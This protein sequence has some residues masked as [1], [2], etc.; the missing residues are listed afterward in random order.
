MLF[1]FCNTTRMKLRKNIYLFSSKRAL[2]M[3]L[4]TNLSLRSF[5][6][7]SETQ[8][9]FSFAFARI[10]AQQLQLRRLLVYSRG[11]SSS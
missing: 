2:Q 3:Y 6:S 10:L 9:T 4:L 7:A 8:K 11:E 5:K 1:C